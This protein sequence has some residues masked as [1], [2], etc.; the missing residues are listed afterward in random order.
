MGRRK[1]PQ[2][3]P[4]LEKEVEKSI[5][6]LAEHLGWRVLCWA[7][8]DRRSR[9][10]PGFPDFEFGHPRLKRIIY[11]EV[12]RPRVGRVAEDQKAWIAF[13]RSCGATVF[14]CDGP[15]SFRDCLKEEGLL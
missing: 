2:P 4:P 12:K 1:Q 11:V 3:E 6:T 9:I 7:R 10:T 14:V 5:R 15:H 13:A 8:R